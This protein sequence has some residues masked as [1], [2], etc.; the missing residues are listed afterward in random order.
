MIL[1]TILNVIFV[2]LAVNVWPSDQAVYHCASYEQNVDFKGSDITFTYDVKKPQDC[3]RVCIL[4]R[5]VCKGFTYWN[6]AKTVCFL[7]DVI[8]QPVRYTAPGRI[9]KLFITSF[10]LIT[11]LVENFLL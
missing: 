2:C 6:D 3:E 7:K 10:V 4:L 8:G 9:I 1:N 5:S 11:F